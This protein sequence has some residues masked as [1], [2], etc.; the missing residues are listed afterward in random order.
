MG[1]AAQLDRVAPRLE[2][3]HDL[4]VLVA[5]EGDGAQLA[6]LVHGGL[7]V[8]HRGVVEDLAV[9]QVLDGSDL[10][11]A[12]RLEVAEVEPQPVGRHQRALLLH[13]GAEHLAQRP[14]QDVGAGVVAADGVAAVAVD[15]GVGRW[16]TS[17]V[18]SRT[19]N[20]W[21]CRPG[22]P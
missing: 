19:T 15:A 16:P 21:R 22:R 12:D 18:P 8:A 13:M 17:I 11:G 14:V 4:A 10:L 5:E 3:P 2:D 20:A 9:G 6:G 7:E 1:A